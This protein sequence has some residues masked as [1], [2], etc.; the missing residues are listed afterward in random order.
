MK[1]EE[2]DSCRNSNADDNGAEEEKKI[3]VMLK[4]MVFQ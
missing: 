1:I 2:V 3:T 4:K